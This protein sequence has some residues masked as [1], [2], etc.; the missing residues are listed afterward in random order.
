M[1]ILLDILPVALFFAVY[2]AA[3]LYA[4]TGAAILA[5]LGQVGWLKA[6]RRPV[7]PLLYASAGLLALLGGL[8]LALRD[9]A[10]IMW[11]P[12]L[13][14]WLFAAVFLASLAT[15][16]SVLER[17]LGTQLAL[18]ARVLRRLTLAWA[19]FFVAAGALN[20]YVAFGYEVS[21][22]QLNDAQRSTY[23]R[24]AQDADT[25]ARSVLGTPLAQLAPTQR[26]AAETLAPAQR[27]GAYLAKVHRDRW[28]SF[29][30]F[31]LL[32]LT[33]AF[34]L[35]QGLFLARYL[36]RQPGDM[37]PPGAGTGAA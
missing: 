21:A 18:P 36:G 30:L 32:G 23:E 10:F 9:D 27:Q 37:L 26:A 4:A 35:A 16:R 34:A 14:N 25:Y 3:G 1:Q 2:K 11:K 13:V 28:V 19:A 7:P 33:L 12:S 5:A 15:R 22:A 6:R 20:A 29:K 8:T 24:L 31:G 17:A